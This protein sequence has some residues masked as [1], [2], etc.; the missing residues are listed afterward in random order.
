MFIVST[1]TSAVTLTSFS[2]TL[3]YL[4]QILF[5]RKTHLNAKLIDTALRLGKTTY[6]NFNLVIER[7]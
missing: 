7:V 6:D 2:S 1:D 3:E 5:F 4:N